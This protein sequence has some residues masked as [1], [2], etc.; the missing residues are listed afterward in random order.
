MTRSQTIGITFIVAYLVLAS[1][2]SEA[3][4]NGASATTD[5]EKIRQISVA[6]D[7]AFAAGDAAA[8]AALVTA[9]AV[10]MPPEE[11]AITG[12]ATIQ[13]RYTN[14]FSELR[15]RF[16]NISHSLEVDDVQ[17]CGDWAISRG[18]YRLEMTLR[19][20]PHTVVVT[21]KNA[22]TYSRQADGRWLIASDI[23]N[24]DAP[25]RREPHQ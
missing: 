8:M 6:I 14:M 25:V 1:T 24:S 2:I 4:V 23:W 20:V 5:V 21:G 9:D 13:N 7:T 12:R 11:P 10:W 16:E 17:V 18:R 15:N 22:H 19:A 3:Q